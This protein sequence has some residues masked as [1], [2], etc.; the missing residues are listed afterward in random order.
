MAAARTTLTRA[1]RGVAWV[2]AEAEVVRR[3][4]REHGLR[5]VL[6]LRAREHAGMAGLDTTVAVATW[7]H[8]ERLAQL[9]AGL[10]TAQRRAEADAERVAELEARL[11]EAER[12][13]DDVRVLAEVA[14][15]E[16]A[17]SARLHDDDVLVSVVLPTHDRPEHLRRAI[18]S[19][20][21]Q[22][23]RRLEL[24]VV[25]T[26][27]RTGTAAVLDEVDDPRVRVVEAPGA[28]SGAARN[29]GLD[30]A[31]GELVTYLDDDNLME[32]WWLRALAMVARERPEA[33][34]FY[35]AR[36][37]EM[38]PG[39]RAIVQFAPA[40]DRARYRHENFIDTNVLAHRR[41]LPLRW[42]VGVGAPDWYFV[43]NLV[44]AG[45]HPV[46]VPVRAALYLSSAPG[47]AS[48]SPGYQERLAAT[49]AEVERLLA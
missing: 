24:L 40:F 22:L 37:I 12:R 31:R 29:A 5:Q 47:R 6:L 35:G 38:A 30:E 3:Y 19:V 36:I 32:P 33:D 28:T 8:H 44:A 1:R 45:H 17:V 2:R 10:A 15:T 20:L 27:G 43:A 9:E 16:R 48:D 34:V 41:G 26:A 13:T 46:P 39:A 4:R 18:G 11:G 21:G 49:R 23:H 42:P 14:A 25:D 7:E